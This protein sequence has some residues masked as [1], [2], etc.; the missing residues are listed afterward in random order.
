MPFDGISL[1]TVPTTGP[2][3]GTPSDDRIARVGDGLDMVG[4]DLHRIAIG[5]SHG[6]R[7]AC[8][9]A[10]RRKTFLIASFKKPRRDPA[11]CIQNKCSR[12]RDAVDTAT[13]FG[14][15]V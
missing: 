6:V 1:V 8:Q 4:L 15:P 2:V 9:D 11:R 5:A 12:I 14:L 3:A 13:H 7:E 10:G